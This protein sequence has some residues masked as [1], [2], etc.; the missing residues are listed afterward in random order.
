[1]ICFFF[2]ILE[3]VGAYLSDSIAIFT[4]VIHLLSDLLGFVFSLFSVYLATKKAPK[5]Y[6]YGYV[7][8]EILGALFSVIIIW[9]MSLWILMESY[10]RFMR[11]IRNEPIY[12]NPTYMLATSILG[13]IINIIMALSLHGHGHGHHHG[14]DHGHNHDHNHD[15]SHEHNHDHIHEDDHSHNHD[16]E[17]V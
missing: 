17:K 1:M 3:T 5:E 8:A 9:I 13:L 11:I 12:L 7:R 16:E 15:H 14:H 10:V 4:D 2:I 6:S